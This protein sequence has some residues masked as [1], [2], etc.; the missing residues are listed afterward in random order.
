MA[1]LPA[2]MFYTGDWLKDPALSKCSPATRGIWTDA[3]CLMHESDRSGIL[4]GTP[5]QLSRC[6]RCSPSDVRA[7]ARELHASG[8]ATVTE[9]HGIVTLVN[10]RMHREHKERELN[11]LRQNRARGKLDV[12]PV[13]RGR[14]KNVTSPSSSSSS[15]SAS[16]PP[17]APQGGR[18]ER[19]RKTMAEQRR[20]DVERLTAEA[21]A[22]QNGESM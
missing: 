16:A 6:L 8:A 19:R 5:E 10:R 17:Q 13:S 2:F 15:I 18:R 20:A 12:T 3:L 4:E 22:K 14:H 9:R 1:K 21:L 7:A 11:R